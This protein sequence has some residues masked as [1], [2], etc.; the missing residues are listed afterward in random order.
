M[1]L[2]PLFAQTGKQNPDTVRCYGLTELRYIA[3]TLVEARACDTLLTISNIKVANRDSMIV[4]KNYEIDQLN[5]QLRVKDQIIEIRDQEIMN[6]ATKLE[7]AERHKRWLKLG[8]GATTLIL[9]GIMIYL[10]GH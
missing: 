4:E 3:A 8:W 2:T 7:K 9:G 10:G 6:L 5:K 1:S